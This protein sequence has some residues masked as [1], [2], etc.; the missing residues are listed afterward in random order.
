MKIIYKNKEY[1]YKEKTSLLEISKNFTSDYK[2]N[3]LLGKVNNEVVELDYIVNSDCE[4]DFYD[5]SHHIG[6][7]A[8]ERSLIFLVISA[9]KELYN[10]N[11][12]IGHSIDKGILCEVPDFYIDENKIKEIKNKVSEYI[13][14]K[15]DF[16]KVYYTRYS[17][18]QYYK[19]N[20][21]YDKLKNLK[22]IISNSLLL[23][24]FKNNF[25][26][27][28]GEML[29][30]SSYIKEFDI[31]FLNEKSFVLLLPN[32]YLNGHIKPYEHYEKIFNGF[33][34]F[35]D[36][37]KSQNIFNVSD[38]NE[39]ISSNKIDELIYIN[40][41]YQNKILYNVVDQILT[42]NNIKIILIGG[43]SS[44]GKTTMSKKLSSFLKSFG[45]EPKYLSIDD[46]FKERNETPI[47]ENGKFD[48]ESINSVDLV[49]FNS[50][51]EKLLNQEEVILPEFNFI[52]GTKEYKR[53]L[54]LNNKSI[55][56]IEGLHAL[57]DNLL[58]EIDNANKFKM[59]VSALSSINIDNHNRVTTSDIR[60]LRRIV[61]DN[62]NRGYSASDTLE[63]WKE[64]RCGEELYVFPF[65][66]KSDVVIN[67]SLVYELGVLR[68]FVEPLLFSVDSG[69]KNYDEAIR[70]INLIRNILPIAQTELPYDSILR[71]FIGNSFFSKIGDE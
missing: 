46:F 17:M 36:F 20:K 59:Y 24:K 29:I 57:D 21:M 8:Y 14:L 31:K 11:I 40:E 38:L 58:S 15:I 54:K 41:S 27:F 19:S 50:T 61:R 55:L 18:E 9:F 68:T 32:I 13:S 52:K 66:N 12:T 65:Q 60:I 67:T 16:E 28:Y 53:K 56:I 42:N 34:S 6:N 71:E 3:I 47:K 4:I 64:V 30:D 37:S 22:Y 70:L 33:K 48:F 26:Y 35:S 69:D 43:P 1:I 39:I 51:L 23:Y 10:Y 45:L 49:L 7:K 63:A 25:N 44:S 62:M 5:L 2:F